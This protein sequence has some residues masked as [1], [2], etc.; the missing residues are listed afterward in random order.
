[1]TFMHI[2][3]D[4]FLFPVLI[5]FHLYCICFSSI[6]SSASVGENGSQKEEIKTKSRANQ[7]SADRCGLLFIYHES[8]GEASCV[9]PEKRLQMNLIT[10]EPRGMS[11]K[12]SA[13]IRNNIQQWLRTIPSP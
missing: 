9:P 13:P 6:A 12:E 11:R 5:H 4:A 1:M 10:P 3:V 8:S 7:H 2:Q